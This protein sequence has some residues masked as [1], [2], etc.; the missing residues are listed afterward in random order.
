[1]Y[2]QWPVVLLAVACQF[3]SAGL[4]VDEEAVT[5]TGEALAAT[6]GGEIEPAGPI[7]TSVGMDEDPT[8]G[9]EESLNVDPSTEGEGTPSTSG[10]PA[11]S[12]EST[13]GDEPVTRRRRLTFTLPSTTSA[14]DELPV[15]VRL[16]AS[17]IDFDLAGQEGEFL[18][19]YA[20][21]DLTPLRYEIERW[22]DV[23][24]EVWVRVP[25]I[26]AETDHIWMYYGA[27]ALDDGSNLPSS[28]WSEAFVGVWHLD[29]SLMDSTAAGGHAVDAGTQST[30]AQIGDGR[31]F[32]GDTHV[33]LPSVELDL[34]E[35]AVSFWFRSRG[36]GEEIQHLFYVAN[37]E[38]GDGFGEAPGI[39][40]DTG[41]EMHIN[42]DIDEDIKRV[43]LWMPSDRNGAG[44]TVTQ[45]GEWIDDRWHHVHAS[46]D[47]SGVTFL[48]V[49]GEPVAVP[50]EDPDG[51]QTT[52]V[53]AS[54]LVRL[55]RP[56]NNERRFVGELDE[57]RWLTSPQPPPWV[58][59][60][61]QS[62]A[63]ALLTYGPEEDV[64]NPPAPN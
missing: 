26:D 29:A 17:R 11:I 64:A 48:W 5:G 3:D 28:V 42:L 15:R 7:V 20:S 6:T 38:D 12:S 45:T 19:F 18:R 50:I 39:L 32:D 31:A 33:D 62:Q 23:D 24:A 59:A 40:F 21:D 56:G 41:S 54:A 27:V 30:L 36:D 46:W 55:G 13:T 34:E 8:S 22:S 51:R 1:M 53:D 63:D 61:F 43:D 10:D 25:H 16:D 35:G 49:D 58:V 2:R 57:V 44:G 60:D 14:F 52:A 47:E 4:G 9:S 37:I